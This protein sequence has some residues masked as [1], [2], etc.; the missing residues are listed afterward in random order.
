MSGYHTNPSMLTRVL[1]FLL[2][3]WLMNIIIS[4]LHLDKL[5]VQPP[6]TKDSP[7]SVKAVVE[8]GDSQAEP[9][10][11]EKLSAITFIENILTMLQQ[12]RPLPGLDLEPRSTSSRSG[13]SKRGSISSFGFP[14][15]AGKKAWMKQ[16][17]RVDHFVDD[18]NWRLGVLQRLSPS[19][20]RP[21]QWREALAVLRAA[22]S[23]LLNM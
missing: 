22:P 21:W 23:T 16:A 2:Q 17:E 8:P 1:V 13:L 9:K 5:E 20:Q 14:G 6:I 19:Y 15:K 7:I 12:C 18:W 3:V 4:L 10:K 11:S